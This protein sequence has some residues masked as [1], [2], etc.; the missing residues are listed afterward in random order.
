MSRRR[1]QRPQHCVLPGK[2]SQDSWE[3]IGLR[4]SAASAQMDGA[5][6]FHAQGQQALSVMRQRPSS[7]A[8]MQRKVWSAW[9][10][11]AGIR[12]RG[13]RLRIVRDRTQPMAQFT[14]LE[15]MQCHAVLSDSNS[16]SPGSTIARRQRRALPS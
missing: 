9:A 8:S 12:L 15:T 13:A 1:T 6:L 2:H 5:G 14:L 3:W 4:R 11:S 10:M 16:L 7:S